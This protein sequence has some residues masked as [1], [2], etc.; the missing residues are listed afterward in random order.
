[1]TKESNK[2]E[3]IINLTIDG[4]EE[5]EVKVTDPHKTIREQIQ[6]IIN[7][8]ELPKT[9]C[10]GHQIQYLLGQML[11]D[12]EELAILEYDDEI[13]N[14]QSLKD[15]NIKNGDHLCLVT[16]PLYGCFW[17]DDEQTNTEKESVGI[18]TDEE[19]NE[20]K[21]FWRHILYGCWL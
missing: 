11:E 15:Y 10:G 18:S 3:L 20:R 7:V 16:P 4:Y 6:S 19:K 12:G 8:F 17:T 13:G 14:P 5:V 2:D 1:M 9:D 21:P